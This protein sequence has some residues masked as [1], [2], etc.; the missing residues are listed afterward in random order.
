MFKRSTRLLASAAASA[1]L[2][3]GGLAI[4][5]PAAEAATPAKTA[6]AFYTCTN[7]LGLPSSTFKVPAKL[8][9]DT[10]DDA[11]LAN[12]P[13]PAG[14]PFT[15][16]LDFSAAGLIPSLLAVV[17]GALN[18]VVG[19]IP[20]LGPQ[21]T[22]QLNLVFSQLQN[23]AATITG[24]LGS[25]VPT[26]GA[27]PIPVPTELSFGTIIPI[28]AP[29]GIKCTL[30]PTSVCSPTATPASRCSPRSSARRSRPRP[31]TR[32]ATRPS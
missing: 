9:L 24:Q 15:A 18:T 32:R 20:V 27:L 21:V 16:E 26:G 12:I 22:P 11:L 13:I 17:Q 3:L 25:F 23:G 2:A 19:Q 30:D 7:P 8:G 1:G 29:L 6:T 4:T 14:T 10:L 28:L 5:A 31:S